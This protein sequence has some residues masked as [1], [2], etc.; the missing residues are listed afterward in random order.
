LAFLAKSDDDWLMRITAPIRLQ[1]AAIRARERHFPLFLLAALLP[2]LLF[3]FAN[4]DGTPLQRLMVPL[5]VTVLVVESLLA[6]PAWV[7]CIGPLQ[8]NTVYR[9]FGMISALGVWWP[10]FSAHRPLL[11]WHLLDPLCALAVLSAHSRAHHSGISQCG[12]GLCSY[13]LPRRRW[14]CTSRSHSRAFS[15]SASAGGF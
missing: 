6:L 3:P 15:Y 5:A 10:L 4:L 1:P 11:I 13:T 7:A 14:L 2:I 8:V 12:S 9:L